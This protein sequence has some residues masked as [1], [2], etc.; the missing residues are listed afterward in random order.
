VALAGNSSWQVLEFIKDQFQLPFFMEIIITFCWSIWMQ[1]NDFI[2]R[3]IQPT[4]HACY[5][6]FKKDFALVI[7]RA[8]SRHKTQML[9][10]LEAL[11]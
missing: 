4:L 5:Q 3:E 2:F 6:A 10:W 1:R 11:V 7:L 9:A 8:K